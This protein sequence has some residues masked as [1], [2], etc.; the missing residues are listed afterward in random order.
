MKSGKAPGIGNITVELLNTNIEF[1]TIKIHELLL[2][3]WMFEVIS[4]A[5]KKGLIIKLPM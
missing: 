5:W 1:S 3:I 4:E 2:K